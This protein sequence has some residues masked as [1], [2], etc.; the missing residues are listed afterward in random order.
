M[1]ASTLYLDVIPKLHASEAGGFTREATRKRG[2]A[3]AV[4]L[5]SNG[6]FRQFKGRRDS[7]KLVNHLRSV[8]CVVGYNCIAFD[9][10]VIRGLVPFRRPK[11]L[12]LFLHF[13]QI[14]GR[15]IS[16]AE[17]L[18]ISCGRSGLAN[19]NKLTVLW[20]EGDQ[21]RVIR[22]VQRKLK[23]M[24]RLH[25]H[26]FPDSRSYFSDGISEVSEH[27]ESITAARKAMIDHCTSTFVSTGKMPSQTVVTNCGSGKA[28]VISGPL[29][30]ENGMIRKP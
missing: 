4:T 26:V 11:T 21:E 13:S 12:D 20:R 22:A 29:D 23:A 17:V 18:K 1:Q 15:N 16:L 28:R 25:E 6:T 19:G 30:C 27:E 3:V 7:E 24:R 10:E 9:Y 5:D 14:A 8:S 2:L